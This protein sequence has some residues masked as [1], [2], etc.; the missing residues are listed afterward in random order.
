VI[1]NN[2]PSSD[3]FIFSSYGI[4]LKY[5]TVLLH[6]RVFKEFS[7]RRAQHIYLFIIHLSKHDMLQLISNKNMLQVQ[8][9]HYMYLQD[10]KV[11]P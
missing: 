10:M 1:F 5:K 7:L 8:I 9:Q 4:E 3:L 2:I 6:L 11:S